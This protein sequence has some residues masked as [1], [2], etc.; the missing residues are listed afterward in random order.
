MN[1]KRGHRELILSAICIALGAATSF[2][3][4]AEQRSIVTQPA[5]TVNGARSAATADKTG[6]QWVRIPGGTYMMGEGAERHLVTIKAFEMAKTVVTNKQ[7]RACVAA[8]AC[9]S[10]DNCGHPSIGDDRPQICVDFAQAQA[11]SKW[12]GARLP[13]EAEWEYAARSAGKDRKYAWGDKDATCDNAVI[14]GGCGRKQTWPVCSRPSGNTAQGLCDMSGNA[15][16]WVQD[17]YHPS[18]KGAPTDG[19]AWES[20]EGAK[21]VFRGG[22]WSSEPIDALTTARDR[23]DPALRICDLS[24][25]PVRDIIGD[26]FK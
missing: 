11:Y 14:S 10:A 7:Y 26:D 2:A 19:S 8:G 13:T 25:R 6:I 3:A 24:F 1:Q 12:A 18:F 17:W 5:Q 9:S 4:P 15:W 16:Q 22:S 20:P 21:R 23:G